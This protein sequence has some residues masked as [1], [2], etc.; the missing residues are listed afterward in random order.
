MTALRLRPGT[1]VSTVAEGLL[2]AGRRRTF[3]IAGPARLGALWDELSGP[4]ARGVYTEELPR[5]LP[6]GWSAAAARLVESLRAHGAVIEAAAAPVDGF[7]ATLASLDTDRPEDA[8]A[9]FSACTIAVLGD[10]TG[11]LGEAIRGLGPATVTDSTADADLVV[12]AD[13]VRR[14]GEQPWLGV[15]FAGA[16]AVVGPVQLTEDTP[17]LPTV[18]ERL[19]EPTTP[20]STSD[21]VMRLAAAVTALSV[22]EFCAGL[23]PRL[24]PLAHLV[25]RDGLRVTRHSLGTD[26][27]DLTD[28]WLGPLVDAPEGDLPQE[29]VPMAS[30]ATVGGPVRYACGDTTGRARANA[31]A[32]AARDLVTGDRVVVGATPAGMLRDAARRL[33]LDLWSGPRRTELFDGDRLRALPFTVAEADGLA[34]WADPDPGV[35]ACRA[36]GHAALRAAVPEAD[37]PVPVL[38]DD[39]ETWDAEPVLR[40]FGA[41]VR[42]C[43]T[44]T[45]PCLGLLRVDR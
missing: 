5:L 18:L 45:W 4:L 29:P 22:L 14:Q 30:A 15:L 12:T 24:A 1:E 13:L 16:R 32:A 28:P 2:V 23:E 20:L 33:V 34:V 35:A 17:G 27:A 25:H 8:F 40:H 42:P 36:H 43:P 21:V 9:W 3:L 31:L 44:P 26:L 6:T 10:A 41:T 19:R 37:D 11:V 38:A 7:P 39:E